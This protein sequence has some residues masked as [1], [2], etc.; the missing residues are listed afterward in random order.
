MVLVLRLEQ[1]STPLVSDTDGGCRSG[2]ISL[3]RVA[4]SVV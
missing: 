4:T 1:L 3:I 2:G